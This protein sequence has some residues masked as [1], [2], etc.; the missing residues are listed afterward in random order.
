MTPQPLSMVCILQEI[1]MAVFIMPMLP[2]QRPRLILDYSFS[3]V[4]QETVQ[5][6]PQHAMQFGHAL[7]QILECIVYANP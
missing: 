7:K 6:A 4:N 5:V 2:P 3:N 1:A